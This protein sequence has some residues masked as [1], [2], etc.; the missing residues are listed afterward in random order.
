MELRRN[1]LSPA[2]NV[3]VDDNCCCV[4]KVCMVICFLCKDENPLSPSLALKSLV[5]AL[6]SNS[7]GLVR[8]VDPS[9]S[10]AEAI[11]LIL[12]GAHC[13]VRR[14]AMKGGVQYLD[15]ARSGSNL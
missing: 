12:Q 14:S 13:L 4:G 9:S 2:K 7:Q 8:H 1:H 10:L 3:V 6:M 11:D 15:K 5:F